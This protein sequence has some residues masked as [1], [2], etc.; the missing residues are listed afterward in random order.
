[1]GN[2]LG[3]VIFDDTVIDKRYAKNSERAKPQY[4]GNA[5]RVINRIRGVTCVY[6]NPTLDRFWIIDYRIYD[7]DTDGKS[8][9][10]PVKEML[11]VSVTDRKLLFETVLMDS[12]NAA[13]AVM[14]HIEQLGKTYY[15]GLTRFVLFSISLEL[16]RSRGAQC[17]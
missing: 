16:C 1:M 15:T 13:K 2:Y 17:L 10:Y 12:W 9:L 11:S 6:L 3:Y 7:Q 8:K 14:L 4:S 5:K